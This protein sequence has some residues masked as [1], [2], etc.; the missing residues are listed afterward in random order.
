MNKYL[1]VGLGNVGI[2]YIDTRHNIGFNILDYISINNDSAFSIEK[3][4]ECA[5]FKLKGKQ[6]YLLK[7]STL[8]NL[9][10]KAVNYYLVNLKIPIQNLLVI[11]DDLNLDFGELK[12]RK[13]GG[14]GGHNGHKHIIEVLKSSNYSRL[15]F[16]IGKNFKTGGQVQYV[17]SKWSEQEKLNLDSPLNL[18]AKI[19]NSFILSGIENTMSNFNH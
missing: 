15:K 16:G 6:V 10:G 4:G 18:S 2:N 12:L 13:K 5:I 3:Y 14:S 7:P 8:M 9:S 19:V 1:I 11:S 17:L